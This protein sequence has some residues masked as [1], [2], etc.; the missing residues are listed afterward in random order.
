LVAAVNTQLVTGEVT[1]AEARQVAESAAVLSHVP[2]PVPATMQ[3]GVAIAVVARSRIAPQVPMTWFPALSLHND[4][5]YSA[6]PR[7]N[8]QLPSSSSSSPSTWV[9]S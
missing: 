5:M 2:V 7:R 1:V 4:G 8:V 3:V 9:S 6:F